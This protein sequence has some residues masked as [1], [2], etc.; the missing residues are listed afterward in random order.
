MQ[1]DAAAILFD[2]DGV[3]VDSHDLVEAAW[4]RL[5]DEFDLQVDVLL[6]E[7]AGVRAADT[8]GRYLDR[9]QVRA[10][11]GRLEDIEVDLASQTQVKAGA[12]ELTV[13]LPGTAW[14][15]VTSASRRLA[16]ARWSAAGLT[17]PA[18]TVTADDVERGKPDP[19]PFLSAA[20]L[21]GVSPGRCVVFEDSASG[22]V[23]AQIAG[24]IPI[25]VG[26]QVW[27]FAPAARILD[28]A[29]VTVA[30]PLAGGVELTLRDEP[31]QEG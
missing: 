13:R 7:L 23:A 26:R 15:I 27:P 25:A 21:L 10:A 31:S 12:G 22:G 19:E 4:R 18:V 16:E 5:A 20:H 11:V 29:S 6:G 9:G 14:A 24:A 1:I 3:L 30:I 17:I 8:L 28:L 2:S